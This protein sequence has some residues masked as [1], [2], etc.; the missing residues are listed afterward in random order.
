MHVGAELRKESIERVYTLPDFIFRPQMHQNRLAAGL[1]SDPLGS[2][3]AP[4]EPLAAVG[5]DNYSL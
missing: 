5:K 2:L 4:P 3:S 1:R